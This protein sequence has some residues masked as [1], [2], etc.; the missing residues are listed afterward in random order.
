M[1]CENQFL[2]DSVDLAEGQFREAQM[3]HNN[4]AVWLIVT[5][6]SGNI[7]AWFNVCPHQGRSLNYA[8]DKFLIDPNGQLICAAHG[9]VFEPENGL[10]INGPCLGASLKAIET[11]EQ[12]GKIFGNVSA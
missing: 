10:C 12:N 4:R 5:R 9:A 11:T 3:Q 1:S 7:R 2:L 6:Q 8:P